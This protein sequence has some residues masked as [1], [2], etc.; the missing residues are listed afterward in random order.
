MKLL[1][2]RPNIRARERRRS[3]II[4]LKEALRI[5][6]LKGKSFQC[7]KAGH[8]KRNCKEYIA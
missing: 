4:S 6:S 2:L 1:L 5:S 8:W 7:G 3:L